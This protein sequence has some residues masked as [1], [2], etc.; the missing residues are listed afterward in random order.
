MISPRQCRLY[1]DAKGEW[2]LENTGSRNG[3]W[4]RVSKAPLAAS[5]QFQLGEQRFYVR[6]LSS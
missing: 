4:L 6:I 2:R 3:T 1:R 5:G